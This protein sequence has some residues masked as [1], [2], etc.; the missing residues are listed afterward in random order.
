MPE[1]KKPNSGQG[2]LTI[3]GKPVI[4]TS[5]TGTKPESF[6][7][8]RVDITAPKKTTSSF[9]AGLEKAI[10]GQPKQDV[11]IVK[12]MNEQQPEITQEQIAA[13]EQELKT[14]SGSSFDIDALYTATKQDYSDV[15]YFG[16]TFIKS[17]EELEAVLADPAQRSQFYNEKKSVLGKYFQF[18]SENDF[19][20]KISAPVTELEYVSLSKGEF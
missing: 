6:L 20:T 3:G 2:G 7:E 8:G 18:V 17:K 19:D 11:P 15:I 10:S 5:T 9:K 4:N 16:N 1:E 14:L 13:R 12:A